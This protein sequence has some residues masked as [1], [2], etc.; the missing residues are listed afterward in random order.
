MKRLI[1]ITLTAFLVFG[2]CSIS[3]A[4]QSAQ[5]NATAD[6]TVLAQLDVTKTNDLNFGDVSP[7]VNKTISRSNGASFDITGGDGASVSLDFTLPTGS[8]YTYALDD[9]TN[10]LELTFANDDANYETG[11]GSSD[12]GNNTFNPTNTKSI[13]SFPSGGITVFLGGTVEPTNNQPANTYSGTI[14]LTATYN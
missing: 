12:S 9:G 5:D 11:T 2:I 1:Q 8:S 3:F 14:T 6:A 13:N 10:E 4:Q 7:G